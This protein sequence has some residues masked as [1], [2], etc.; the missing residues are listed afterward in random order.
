MVILDEHK[1]HTEQ[2]KGK[3][4]IS[5]CVALW[6]ICYSWLLPDCCVSSHLELHL[7]MY[8]LLQATTPPYLKLAKVSSQHIAYAKKQRSLAV[9]NLLGL[10][11]CFWALCGFFLGK[12][13][14][15]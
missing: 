1:L 3:K 5:M 15:Q 9:C 14:T 10:G 8:R 6:P 12:I 7:A 4:V 11:S 2:N 13:F